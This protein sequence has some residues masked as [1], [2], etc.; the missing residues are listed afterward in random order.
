MAPRSEK[1]GPVGSPGAAGRVPAPGAVSNL[2][3][4]LSV[5]C[6]EPKEKEE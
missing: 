6:V 2:P 5:L 4:W 3:P 1:H